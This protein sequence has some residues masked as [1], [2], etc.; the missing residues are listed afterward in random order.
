MAVQDCW[1]DVFLW[2]VSGNRR[3]SYFRILPREIVFSPIEE[4][5][6]EFCGTT[7]TICFYVCRVRYHM[8]K[9][10]I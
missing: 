8:V 4:E 3:I 5:R 1:P 6:G 10:E 7:R 9:S 2:M